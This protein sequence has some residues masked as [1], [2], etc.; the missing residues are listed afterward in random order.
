MPP[1]FLL[2]LGLALLLIAATVYLLTGRW[3]HSRIFTPLNYSVSL[4]SRQL[5]SP[6]FQINL[7]EEYFVSLSLDHVANTWQEGHNCDESNLLGSEWRVYKLSSKTGQSRVLWADSGKVE[8]GYELY[9]GTMTASSG[10][11]VL[12]WDLPPNAACLRQRHAQLA[13]HTG[14]A[15]YEI[16]VSFVQICCVFLVG[17]GA[18]LMFFAIAR[19]LRQAVGIAEGPR[20]F[21]DMPLRNVLPIAKH[22]PLLPIHD[23]P[24]WGLFCGAVLWILIFISMVF[25]PLPSKGLYV[26]WRNHDAVVWETSP[27]SDTIEVYVGTPARFFINGEEVKRSE[28]GSKLTEKLGRRAEWT[29]YFEADPDTLFMDDAYA[30]DTIQAC[31]AKVIWVTPKMR[32]EWQH[33][34]RAVN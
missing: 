24:H 11:Y 12:E 4:D 19:T 5:K 3:L 2:R 31:G 28:L 22:K 26:S 23:M 13:V 21:P 20:M 25:S 8:Q 27:W 18:A 7:R 29:V 15:G 30:L 9:I 14:R 34:P 16:L 6:P 1:K 10:Q 32:K 17:T 33:K